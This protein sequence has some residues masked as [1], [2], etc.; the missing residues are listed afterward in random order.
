M[1]NTFRRVSFTMAMAAGLCLAASSANAQP[2]GVT[3]DEFKCESGTGKALTKFVGAK[4][5]CVSKCLATGRKASGPYTECFAPFGG[6]TATCIQDASK[7]AEAKAR[8]AIIKACSKDC[9]ECYGQATCDTGE[10]FVMT[11]EG[12]LDAQ[13]PLV[14]CTENGGGTPTKE[15][16]KCE[17]AVSK[18]LVK[19]VGAYSKCYDKCNANVFN[20]KIAEGSCDPPATDPAT[21]AC[22]A[23]AQP[24]AIDGIDKACADAGANP[25]CYSAALDSGA[26]WV[27]L[28]EGILNG[29]IPTIACGSPS[30]AFID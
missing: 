28:T 30:G 18:S 5:K 17:D 27:A 10:P 13:G 16:G 11:T 26:E 3:K 6:A 4:S 7:G 22:I 14:Y 12:L 23:K 25:S 1:S 20:G 29:Q 9:P 24:K 8:A 19:Y 2:A 15:V 21:Q